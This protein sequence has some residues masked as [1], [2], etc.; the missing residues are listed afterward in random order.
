MKKQPKQL[1][2][3]EKD[4]MLKELLKLFWRLAIVTLILQVKR[5]AL[6]ITLD[7]N[8]MSSLPNMLNKLLELLLL[9]TKIFKRMK[10]DQITSPDLKVL[11][12]MILKLMDLL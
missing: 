11:S 2:V 12:A 5:L 8:S 7:K 6:M 10:V 1:M 9:H 3:M 4:S